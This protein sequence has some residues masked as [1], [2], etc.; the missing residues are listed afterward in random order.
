MLFGIWL[1]VFAVLNTHAAPLHYPARRPVIIIG[2]DGLS[3]RACGASPGFAPILSNS[4]YTLRARA[5]EYT[6]SYEGWQANLMGGYDPDNNYK[7]GAR[8][9]PLFNYIRS[10]MPG[11]V[12]WHIGRY[13][14]IRRSI[15]HTAADFYLWTRTAVQAADAF[16]ANVDVKNPP[17]LSV[18]YFLD[19]DTAG[20]KK[21]WDSQHYKNTVEDVAV[22]IKR[23]HFALPSALI[24][25][26]SDHGGR[27]GGHSYTG[28]DMRSMAAD[29]D[30]P[31]HRDVPWLRYGD[32]NPRPLCDTI[33]TDE[34]AVEVAH[35]LGIK[36]HPS[37]RTRVGW[38]PSD[39]PCTHDDVAPRVDSSS[40]SDK[41]S[42]SRRVMLWAVTAVFLFVLDAI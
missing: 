16:V 29:L 1:V 36:A 19:I 4:S 35:S 31:W 13:Y 2:V 24:F 28:R 23:I 10:Q 41:P 3:A 40:A 33:R 42:N 38:L 37:W 12:L 5:T 22:Q 27:G 30:S 11:A 15:N 8:H 32:P 18:I 14:I 6:R 20:H 26:I 9:P 21:G 7:S 39:F 17:D 25:I 34:T